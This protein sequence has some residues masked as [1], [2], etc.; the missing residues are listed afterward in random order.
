V[1]SSASS[2]S[3]LVV[4]TQMQPITVIF[5]LSED[6]LEPVLAQLHK[7]VKLSV[8]AYDRSFETN[9]A[10]G[11][12]LAL[13]NQIDTTTGTVKVRAV[14]NNENEALFP[15]Q[16][17]NTLLLRETLQGVTLIPSSAIQQNGQ[18]SFVYVL[19]DNVAH[20]REVKPGVTNN[21]LTQVDGIN[22]GDIVA[23]SSFDK[24][25]DNSPVADASAGGG[26]GKGTKGG[27]K[28]GGKD[29]GG[30]KSGGKDKSDGSGGSSAP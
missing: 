24:L 11:E 7:K 8:D 12:L 26:A 27:G 4:I 25:Q 19:E 3:P 16:F 21:G 15:N 29:S 28:N 14:F 20:I 1:Q 22:P 18:T 10:S 30:K 6:Q 17:V 13:D 23:N 9:L 2:G 5:T